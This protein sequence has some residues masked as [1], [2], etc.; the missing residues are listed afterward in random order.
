[1]LQNKICRQKKR[2]Q[3]YIFRSGLTSWRQSKPM[4]RT[5]TW[6]RLLSG[7]SS[8]VINHECT[9]CPMV[10]YGFLEQFYPDLLAKATPG[11]RNQNRPFQGSASFVV[12]PRNAR[13]DQ[14]SKRIFTQVD[15][16]SYYVKYK[17]FCGFNLGFIMAGK[18]PFGTWRCS[19]I[20]FD[21]PPLFLSDVQ[22]VAEA[23]AQD[24]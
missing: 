11:V 9:P 7:P 3:G 15:R 18:A 4:S 20:T 13:T 19:V 22:K 8:C 23:R 1:M 21:D 14:A 10:T 12:S 5:Q 6:P 16:V 2:Q 17:Q 24:R